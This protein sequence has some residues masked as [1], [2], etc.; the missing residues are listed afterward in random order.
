MLQYDWLINLLDD[1]CSATSKGTFKHVSFACT[2]WCPVFINHIANICLYC[3][4]KCRNQL[5]INLIDYYLV[6]ICTNSSTFLIYPNTNN[7]D[8]V[9]ASFPQLNNELEFCSFEAF[10]VSGL[11]VLFS[12][13]WDSTRQSSIVLP[14]RIPVAIAGGSPR[15]LHT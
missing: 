7:N 10:V 12:V 5:H 13:H 2:P 14:N 1:T 4:C 11:L 6:E 3:T 8:T 15:Q 9:H